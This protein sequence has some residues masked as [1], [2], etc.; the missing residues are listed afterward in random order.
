MLVVVADEVVDLGV[1]L[2][3]FVDPVP[4]I[5]PFRTALIV[6]NQTGA[7]SAVASA[8][9]QIA[10]GV[11]QR[12]APNGTSAIVKTASVALAI[13]RP[14]RWVAL[15]SISWLAI[16]PAVTTVRRPNDALSICDCSK[17]SPSTACP[18]LSGSVTTTSVVTAARVA[19][20]I[21]RLAAVRRAWS[22]ESSD[23]SRRRIGKIAARSPA[24]IALAGPNRVRMPRIAPTPA[25]PTIAKT[26]QE[27]A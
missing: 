25:E 22:G 3:V 26:S 4:R 20:A 17:T 13:M 8:A 27:T 15:S 2:A 11:P 6:R 24:P 18:Q 5:G 1:E 19:I 7:L 23:M 16:T 21:P 12:H 10:P 9:I 14:R